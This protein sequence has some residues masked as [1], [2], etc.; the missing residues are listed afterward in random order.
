MASP[1]LKTL[2]IP[3]QRVAAKIGRRY[4]PRPICPDSPKSCRES[5]RRYVSLRC[6]GRRPCRPERLQRL[7]GPTAQSPTHQGAGD[8]Q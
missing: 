7:Q 8:E 1:T 6:R 3:R 4:V 2:T 5:F